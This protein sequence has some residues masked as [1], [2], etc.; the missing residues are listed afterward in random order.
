MTQEEF[1]DFITENAISHNET[2]FIWDVSKIEEENGV[3][4]IQMGEFQWI[5]PMENEELD[6][7]NER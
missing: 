2:Q 1:A 4:K 7:P 3:I 5:D 6:V